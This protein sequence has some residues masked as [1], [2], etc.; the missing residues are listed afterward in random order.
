MPCLCYR[1]MCGIR[2]CGI[3]HNDTRVLLK[4]CFFIKS[5]TLNRLVLVW[6]LSFG[7]TGG[8]IFLWRV[9]Q[10][11][12]AD[13]M[14]IN[15]GPKNENMHCFSALLCFEKSPL[16]STRRFL[17]FLKVFFQVDM[18]SE[19]RF[20]LPLLVSARPVMA[21]VDKTIDLFLC[22]YSVAFV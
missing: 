19:A 18:L 5:I 11:L 2:K 3:M 4:I 13:G 22:M 17:D 12:Y 1:H 7:W 6:C 8:H 20:A 10:N 21:A 9:G 16:W 14:S 15:V